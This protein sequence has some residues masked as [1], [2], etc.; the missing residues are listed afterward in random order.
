MPR[1][2]CR[3]GRPSS[4]L[5]PWLLSSK[6]SWRLERPQS[7]GELAEDHGGSSPNGSA[8]NVVGGDE[9]RAAA[10]F[11]FGLGGRRG[12]EEQDDLGL[13]EGGHFSGLEDKIGASPESSLRR[14]RAR[15]RCGRSEAG[16]GHR[17]DRFVLGPRRFPLRS[18]GGQYRRV[19][20]PAAAIPPAG[21]SGRRG[22][23]ELSRGRAGESEARFPPG[24]GGR[25]RPLRQAMAE[26]QNGSFIRHG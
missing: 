25:G 26:L 18:H 15:S 10:R 20:R 22:G 8:R 24:R 21:R 5:R 9:P 7:G 6:T 19:P 16:T 13:D 2:S 17:A 11:D 1:T 14:A 4:R 3:P 12:V 23:R